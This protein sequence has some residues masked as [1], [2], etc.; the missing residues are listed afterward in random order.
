[1]IFAE[2]GLYFFPLNT[3]LIKSFPKYVNTFLTRVK[4][5]KTLNLLQPG[6]KLQA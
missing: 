4:G 2:E 5:M 6:V 1:M 3:V